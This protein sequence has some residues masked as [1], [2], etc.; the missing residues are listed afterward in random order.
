MDRKVNIPM[1]LACVLLCLTL[2]SMHL[3][4]G[5]FARYTAKGDGGDSA[6]VAK[7]S[8]LSTLIPQEE[9]VS[10]QCSPSETG[11]FDLTVQN[12]SEVA[13]EYTVDVVLDQEVDS[14]LTVSLKKG[15]TETAGVL[16]ADNKTYTFTILEILSPGDSQVY[17]LSFAVP[18]WTYLTENA[19][20]ATAAKALKFTV[21]VNAQQID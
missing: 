6:R 19:T 16:Q 3:T 4:G 15:E 12:R 17:D 18:D 8:V 5:L 9:K 7:F 1:A 13:V 20:G 10:F 11:E 14:R 21:N 2:I